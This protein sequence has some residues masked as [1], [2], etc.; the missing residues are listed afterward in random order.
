MEILYLKNASNVSIAIVFI[1]VLVYILY[2]SYKIIENKNIQSI[3]EKYPGLKKSVS[4]YPSKT[5]LFRIIIYTIFLILSLASLLNPSF[6]S[7]KI[8]DNKELKGVDLV[9]VIDVSLSMNAEDN[10][11]SRFSVVKESI[12]AILPY[13]SG[14]RFGIITFA[15]SPFL[16][17]PM[18]GDP[19]AFSDYVRGLES[20]MIPD[21]G[22][23]IK[24]AFE[25]AETL[26]KSQ[27]VYRNRLLILLTDGEDPK[28]SMPESL[29]GTEVLV[30]GIGTEEGSLIRYVDEARGLSGFLTKEGTLSGDPRDPLLIHSPQNIDFLKKISF[31]LNGQYV[32]LTKNPSG[33]RD[34]IK[35]VEEMEKNTENILR[36]YSK[37]D[38]YQYI[39]F[40]A[41]LFIMFDL[42][43]I[44]LYIYKKKA[45][46]RLYVKSISSEPQIQTNKFSET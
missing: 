24:K 4:V 18:T 29:Q 5:L 44:E 28:E 22:T 9:F 10:G 34:V 37:K 45:N 27:K 35:R 25:K 32:N 17:C 43:L 20:D 26:L 36:E 19:G 41:L 33:M 21:T 38:G 30:F 12:L 40:P 46:I 23:N 15:G 11:L 39:L 1:V 42:L 14:N 16:Y 31:R 3:L 13:L 6:E 7:D 8:I 2:I